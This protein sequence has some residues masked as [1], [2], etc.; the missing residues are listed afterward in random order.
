MSATGALEGI[1]V[2]EWAVWLNGP[3]TAALMGDLG[4]EVIKIED[5]LH[6]DAT[7]G[8]ESMYGESMSVP[9]G[10]SV[11]YEVGNRSKKSITLNL[12]TEKGRE[13]L[14]NLVQKSDAFLT[15]FTEP[16]TKKLKADYE[17]LRRYNPKLV[18]GL[19][20]GLGNRGPDA[21]VRS[22]DIILQARS[23]SMSLAGDRD[24]DE[25]FV[26]GAAFFDQIGASMLATAVVTALLSRERT[27]KGQ[28]V[29]TSILGAALFAQAVPI[30]YETL[31]GRARLKHT[32]RGSKNPLSNH[33]VCADGKWIL[34]CEPYSD[35]FWEVFCRALGLEDWLKR[36][37]LST[38]IERR[39][40]AEELN[41]GIAEVFKKRDRDE[42][43][44][45]SRNRCRGSPLR[46]YSPSRK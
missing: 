39:K 14:Y 8:M 28:K 29:E 33:Y 32:R 25:P 21:E 35:R 13:I 7:R 36:P 42:W 3:S 27:G 10:S 9:G 1:R 16:L 45:S 44:A 4:A 41:A 5:P 43:E 11:L 34:L 40:Y 17:T 6:G 18:Y 20:S 23:G 22:F 19:A 46:R 37:E 2:L 30:A 26:M 38:S 12:K 15:N 31:R 24:Y